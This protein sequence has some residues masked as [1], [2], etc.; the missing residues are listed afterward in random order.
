MRCLT[1][2][3]KTAAVTVGDMNT[4][5]IVAPALTAGKYSMILTNPD[6]DAASLHASVSAN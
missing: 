3:G 5:K 1:I 2:A 4:L 6:G